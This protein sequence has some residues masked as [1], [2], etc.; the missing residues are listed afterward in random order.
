MKKEIY[1]KNF[2]C[3]NCGWQAE[4]QGV[5]DSWNHCPN[6]LGGIHE[7]DTDYGVCGGILEPIGIW[8]KKNGEWMILKRCSLCGEMQAVPKSPFDNPLKVL[9]VAS[10]PLSSPPF[11]IERTEE[12]TKMMGGSGEI[13]GKL[14]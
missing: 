14:P 5:K 9:S 1:R 4:K 2:K 11:P 7:E 3:P 10:K 13:G 12:L 6:C 8:V